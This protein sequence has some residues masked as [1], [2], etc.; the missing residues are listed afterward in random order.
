MNRREASRVLSALPLLMATG[1]LGAT[2]LLAQPQQF[3]RLQAAITA[4]NDAVDFMEKAPDDFGGHK[5]AAMAAC[6][7]AVR[8]LNL[9]MNY[10]RRGG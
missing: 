6:R 7:G 8:Q 2:K 5:A 10:R 4:I 9:A 1:G 3:P